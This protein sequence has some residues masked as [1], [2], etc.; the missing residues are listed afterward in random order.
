MTMARLIVC[1][2]VACASASASTWESKAECQGDVVKASCADPKVGFKI[3]SDSTGD[4]IY[5]PHDNSGSHSVC[6]CADDMGNTVANMPSCPAKTNFLRKGTT[7]GQGDPCASATYEIYC[8]AT[9]LVTF[10]FVTRAEDYYVDEKGVCRGGKDDSFWIGFNDDDLYWVATG[11]AVNTAAPKDGVCPNFWTDFTRRTKMLGKGSNKLYIKERE[12][13]SQLKSLKIVGGGD[14]CRFGS[15]Q[16]TT[17]APSITTTIEGV[18][19]DAMTEYVDAQM[20]ILKAEM[21]AESK[22]RKEAEASLQQAVATIEAESAKRKEAEASLQKAVSD[23]EASVTALKSKMVFTGNTGD[24]VAV[25]QPRACS[26][27]KASDC[28][29]PEI[30]TNGAGTLTVSAPADDVLV[31]TKDCGS[32]SVCEL[33]KAVAELKGFVVAL[34]DA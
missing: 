32:I 24:T 21:T 8:D 14:H 17:Q 16:Y 10:Q 4:F 33:R 23:V 27:G 12:N 7:N 28:P 1:A 26:K 13:G 22:K 31:E 2:A 15:P 20:K 29:A 11:V 3:K 9:A 18:G 25:A 30:T 5:E 6:L 19:K 34:G